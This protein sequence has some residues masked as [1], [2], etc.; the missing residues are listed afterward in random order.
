MIPGVHKAPG[1]YVHYLVPR[2]IWKVELK[3]LA[4]RIGLK[5]KDKIPLRQLLQQMGIPAP[6]DP[7]ILLTVDVGRDNY[8][9]AWK[10]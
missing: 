5:E 2:F 1:Q 10:Q 4:A 7:D 8:V 6:P 3:K 9:V